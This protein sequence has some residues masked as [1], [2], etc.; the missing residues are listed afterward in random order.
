MKN[1]F[2]PWAIGLL[3]FGCL[4][5]GIGSLG[6]IRTSGEIEEHE[7][8]LSY[9]T[10]A[11]AIVEDIETNTSRTRRSYSMTYSPVVTYQANGDEYTQNLEQLANKKISYWSRGETLQLYYDPKNPE[12]VTVTGELYDDSQSSERRTKTLFTVISYSFF[13][14]GLTAGLV[15]FVEKRKK[16]SH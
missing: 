16:L 11:T 13:G 5:Y 10:T 6:S 7:R 15:S 4:W 3:L 9:E 14:L 1:F 8:V 12:L 2:T